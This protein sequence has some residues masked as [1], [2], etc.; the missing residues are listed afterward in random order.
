MLRRFSGVFCE[1]YKTEVT[2]H[3]VE[4]FYQFKRLS[5]NSPFFADRL[6]DYQQQVLLLLIIVIWSQVFGLF[7]NQIHAFWYRSCK[8]A[9][10]KKARNSKCRV[11]TEVG[12]LSADGFE[13]VVLDFCLLK[14][15]HRRQ[16]D[17]VDFN[18]E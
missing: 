15:S 1:I 11:V 3:C 8:C 2:L 4:W 5:K 14:A 6:L 17:F 16:G 18:R 7:H 13:I 9:H 10:F 12:W